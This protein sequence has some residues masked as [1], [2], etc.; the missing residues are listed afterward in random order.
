MLQSHDWRSIIIHQAEVRRE[1]VDTKAS[2]AAVNAL[3][4]R[5]QIDQE[6][7]KVH[8]ASRLA[9]VG[10][11]LAL[12]SCGAISA[13]GTATR[14]RGIS[15]SPNAK[16]SRLLM[17]FRSPKSPSKTILIY[18]SNGLRPTSIIFAANGCASTAGFFPAYEP[19]SN[20]ASPPFATVTVEPISTGICTAML[21]N[22]DQQKGAT[23]TIVVKVGAAKGE[24]SRRG[25]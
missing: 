24:G 25:K 16:V 23:V 20:P 22:R 12:V 11:V 17:H 5:S 6:I 4:V 13:N 19:R 10:L 2:E 21:E 3:F 14:A 8:M 9:P 15:L 7:R 1:S 18:A